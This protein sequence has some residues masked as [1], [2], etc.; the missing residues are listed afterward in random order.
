MNEGRSR[1][2]VCVHIALCELV[3]K[4]AVFQKKDLA[5]F[6]D[7]IEPVKRNVLAIDA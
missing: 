4:L 2:V 6:L 3:V 7:L 1:H 5:D